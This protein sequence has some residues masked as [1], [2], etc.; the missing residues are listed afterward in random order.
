MI[1]FKIVPPT[2]GPIKVK[3]LSGIWGL[4]V[5]GLGPISETPRGFRVEGF[6]VYRV[7]VVSFRVL[8]L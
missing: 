6:R 4:G 5:W 7:T 8:G 2:M 1:S 3:R